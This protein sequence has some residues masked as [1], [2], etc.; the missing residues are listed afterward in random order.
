MRL[1]RFLRRIV[2]SWFGGGQS[3]HDPYARVRVPKRRGPSDRT[4][5]VAVEEPRERGG[6][7]VVSGKR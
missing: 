1:I 2:S 7:R 3:P 5:A 4:A 6:V